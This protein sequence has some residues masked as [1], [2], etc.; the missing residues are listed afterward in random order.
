MSP[1]LIQGSAFEDEQETK[2]GGLQN[3][4]QNL[5]ARDG[6]MGRHEFGDRAQRANPLMLCAPELGVAD[7]MEFLSGE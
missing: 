3:R 5:I 7:G 1:C 4:S 2:Q 6:F